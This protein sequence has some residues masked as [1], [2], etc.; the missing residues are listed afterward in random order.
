MTTPTSTS[1]SLLGTVVHAMRRLIGAEIRGDDPRPGWRSTALLVA[2]LG[3]LMAWALPRHVQAGD[4]GEFATIMLR[5]GIP[6]PSGYPWMRALGWLGA[7][8]LE[9]IGVPPVTAAALV[10]A[11]AALTGWAIL[12]RIALRLAYAA[13]TDTRAADVTATLVVA[14][15]AASPLVVVHTV[16]AEVWGPL[17]LAVALVAWLAIVRTPHPFVLGV[18]IG[19]ATSHHLTA[20]LLVP[21]VVGAAWP[22]SSRPLA[23]LR[24]GLFGLAGSAAGLLPYSTL[25]IRPRPGPCAPHGEG[26]WWWGD[27]G[28]WRGLLHHV[29]RADYGVLSLSLHGEQPPILDQLGR[30]ATSIGGTL[31]AGLVPFAWG[32]ALVVLLLLLLAIARRPPT[33]RVSV[34]VGLLANI[35]LALALFP[36]AHDIDPTN[37]FGAWILE[38]FDLLGLV[39]LTLPV[40]VGLMRL[41]DHASRAPVR[42]SMALAGGLLVLRQVALLAS[43]GPPSRNDVVERHA[44]DVLRTP[45]PD[46][47]AIVFGTDDHRLFPILYVQEVAGFGNDVIYVDA[48]LLAHDWYRARL[49]QRVRC[50]PDHREFGTLPTEDKP[51]RMM[52]ALWD[53]PNWREVPIYITHPF[54]GPAARLPRAPEGLLWRIVPPDPP[55]GAFEAEQVLARHL[56]ALSR[57]P[58]PLPNPRDVGGDPFAVDLAATYTDT[59]TA[60]LGA[61]TNEGRTEDARTLLRAF[62]AQSQPRGEVASTSP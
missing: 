2:A 26:G 21:L 61:L 53:D 24:A 9:A 16:D 46:R 27:T 58:A 62:A 48:S 19:L 52:G 23:V 57:Y 38:R 18:A 12:H 56:E 7:S 42:W 10:C 5:G 41:V 45:V 50:G 17:V 36:M 1:G 20:V 54:S 22:S 14:L 37:P 60:L 33:V 32:A 8:P 34:W 30:V 25:A 31:T 3:V 6:H 43:H 13:G 4:A 51:L 47:P 49:E 28:T 39:L 35:V 11:T 29:S 44:R 40:T 59:T 15:I 55:E